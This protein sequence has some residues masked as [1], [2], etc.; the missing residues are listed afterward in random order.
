[1][2]FRYVAAASGLVWMITG[3][4]HNEYDL[5]DLLD[6]ASNVNQGG[7]IGN[8]GTTGLGGQPEKG[9]TPSGG[10][11][12]GGTS[13][14][15]AGT[16]DGGQ[17]PTAGTTGALPDLAT[18]YV[19]A[20][21]LGPDGSNTGRCQQAGHPT[22][23]CST[24]LMPDPKLM[25]Y[26][27]TG[28]QCIQGFNARLTLNPESGEPDYMNI[29]GGGMA[30]DF[31]RDVTDARVA[32]NAVEVGI[33]GFSFDI[34]TPPA[35]GLR[36]ELPSGGDVEWAVAYWGARPEYPPSPVKAG[37]NVVLFENVLSPHTWSS[38]DPSR[39]LGISFVIPT[40]ESTAI[41]YS[42]CISNLKLL[43]ERP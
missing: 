16:G 7:V 43:T 10:I 5:G 14:G 13:N 15:G 12:A 41:P 28:T 11:G 3:C 40:S 27:N 2:R 17:V 9:G 39:W 38:F 33:V 6:E 1:M 22:S 20:D 26:A 23:D 30:F 21:G 36:V 8:G 31:G 25:P 37:S 34:D 18:W 4:S 35:R 19:F 29:S 42:F 24:V 32:I